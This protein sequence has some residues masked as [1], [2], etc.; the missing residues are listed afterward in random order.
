MTAS[1]STGGRTP[2]VK[3]EMENFARRL[4]SVLDEKN[5]SQAD[6]A[7]KIWGSTTDSRGFDVARNRDRIS[8]YLA[9]KS[10]PDSK[11]LR[12]IAEALNMKAEELAPDIIA[13]TVERENPEIQFTM[14]SGHTDKVYLRVNKLVPLAVAAQIVTLLSDTT[15]TTTTTTA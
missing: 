10:M 11:N 15:T 3:L 8:V 14:V 7:R 2:V 13:A 12:A 9:G 1:Q 6:L 5:M 4:K